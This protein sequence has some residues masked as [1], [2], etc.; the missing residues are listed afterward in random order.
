MPD[1]TA[2]IADRRND[3]NTMIAGLHAATLLFHNHALALSSATD[4]ATRF[5]EARRLTTWHYQWIVLHEFLPAIVGQ[6]RVDQVLR[7][8]RKYRPSG[9][10]F[11]PVEFR[12]PAYRLHTLARPSYRLN[13]TGG[14]SGGPLFLF[15][16][17][18]SQN[19]RSDP[20]DLR[21]GHR[22]RR[23]FV[24]WRRSSGFPGFES[25][26]R[27]TKKL[28]RLLSTPLFTLPLRS[29]RDPPTVLAQRNLLR[30][31]TWGIPSGQAIAQAMGEEAA[32]PERPQRAARLRT[33][34]RPVDAALVTR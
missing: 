30:H 27:N 29:R 4:P 20:D 9:E 33:R 8:G 2:V 10:P 5:A 31:V 3:E 34:A 21:G 12:S 13:F 25:S 18:P 15:L 1:G 16:F 28:D 14:L 24:D 26:M 17:H 6:K 19:G 7:N 32:R 22:A 11:I 23:R